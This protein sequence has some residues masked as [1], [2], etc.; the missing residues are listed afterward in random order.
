M[1]A[2]GQ[3][4]QERD[5]AR[6]DDFIFRGRDRIESVAIF[7]SAIRESGRARDVGTDVMEHLNHL[8][9]ELPDATRRKLTRRMT[10]VVLKAGE[11]LQAQGE[12]EVCAYF[13]ESGLISLSRIQP[14]GE[15]VEAGL[16]GR[17][18]FIGSLA[19]DGVAFTEAKVEMPG[20]AHCIDVRVL[21]I[22][23]DEDADVRDVLARYQRYQLEEAQL[24][25]ACNANHAIE[26]RL[27]KW[28]LRCLDRIDGTTL[29]LT[30]E[31]VAEMLGVQRTSVTAALQ[32]LVTKGVVRTGRGVIEVLDRDRLLPH[33]CECYGQAT[34][35][36][37][38]LGFPEV[39]D[40]SACAA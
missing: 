20:E 37:P 15:R 14:D 10:H 33:A 40:E 31:F 24:N 22:F 2:A 16:I 9:C 17:E 25:A 38:E 26:Q 8:L 29:A 28:L 7:Y 4:F 5:A 1:G 21:Q 39:A 27:S 19:G 13:P 34:E 36:L 35:R 11:T 30:Q 12:P 6:Q 32:R 3:I 23:L 18:G